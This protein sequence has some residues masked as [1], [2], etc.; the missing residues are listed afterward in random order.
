LVSGNFYFPDTTFNCLYI[1]HFAYIEKPP[2]SYYHFALFG[3]FVA[4]AGKPVVAA[5][6]SMVPKD[7][8]W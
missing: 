8:G 7:N 6:P 2:S 1:K 4:A 3:F 5:G